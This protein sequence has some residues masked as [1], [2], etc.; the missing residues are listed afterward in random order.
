MR[1]TVY[2]NQHLLVNTMVVV[3][4]EVVTVRDWSG[5]LLEYSTTYATQLTL[6]CEGG[7]RP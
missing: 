3:R 2:T 6:R 5:L 1:L 4:V 7:H